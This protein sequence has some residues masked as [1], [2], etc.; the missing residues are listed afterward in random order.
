MANVSDIMSTDI[1]VVEPQ[2]TLLRAAQLMQ[3]LDVGALPVC[4]GRQLLG[5]VTD[6]DITIRGVAAGLVPQ[7]A[8]VSD[9]MTGNVEFCTEEQDTLEVLRV[10][11]DKQVR[12]L[13]VIDVDKNL[14]GIV[15]LGDLALRQPGH[16]DAAVREISEPGGASSGVPS[17]TGAGTAP[18]SDSDSDSE[19]G[20]DSDAGRAAS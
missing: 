2:D 14:V 17:G 5:M 10:M 15:S 18:D 3:Q 12:R 8:C 4:S 16:I 1:Q 13:P 20:S 9:V 6:R 19:S 7:E 11:G